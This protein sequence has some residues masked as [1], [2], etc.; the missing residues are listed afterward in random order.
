MCIYIYIY[1][2]IYIGIYTYNIHI[3][4]Y[5]HIYYIYYVYCIFKLDKNIKIRSKV[6]IATL[7]PSMGGSHFHINRI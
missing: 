7:H 2:Y 5:I 3:Y 1:I 6:E 4:I